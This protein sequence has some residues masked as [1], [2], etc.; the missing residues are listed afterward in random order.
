M[1]YVI[2]LST[3]LLTGCATIGEIEGLGEIGEILRAAEST[4]VVL[5]YKPGRNN[6]PVVNRTIG[7]LNSLSQNIDR[8]ELRNLPHR[9]QQIKYIGENL[10]RR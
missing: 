6:A 10:S 4:R 7:E 1:K 9:V 3:I 5:G 2:I 8:T